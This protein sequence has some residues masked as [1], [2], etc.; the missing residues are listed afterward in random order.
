MSGIR[1]I[2]PDLLASAELTVDS[3]GE[4]FTDITGEAARFLEECRAGE[5]ALLLYLRH[6]SAALVIQENADPDV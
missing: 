5:G 3:K 4:G 6:T 1:S 2:A